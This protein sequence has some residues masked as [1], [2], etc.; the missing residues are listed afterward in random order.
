ML[1]ALEVGHASAATRLLD[2]RARAG[3]AEISPEM[4][5]DLLRERDDGTAIWTKVADENVDAKL[6]ERS[7]QRR[8]FRVPISG[9]GHFMTWMKLICGWREWR[10]C[11]LAQLGFLAL[12]IAMKGDQFV[13]CG[14]L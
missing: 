4:V 14:S 2:R 12:V 3:E 8:L 9:T 6:A 13:R 5:T 7:V 10:R 11:T 1:A